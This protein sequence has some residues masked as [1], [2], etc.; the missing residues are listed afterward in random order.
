MKIKNY[1]L[2]TANES[3]GNIETRRIEEGKVLELVT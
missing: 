1:A 3:G 2:I